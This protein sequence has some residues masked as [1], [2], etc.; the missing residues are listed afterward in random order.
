MKKLKVKVEEISKSIFGISSRRY[1]QLASDEIVPAVIH[2]KIDFIAASKALI[3]YYRNLAAG[4]G[5]L[6]LTDVRIRKEAARAE[7]EELIVKKLKGELVPKNAS[8]SWLTS[9][10]VATKIAFRGL[11]KRL[12]P[13]VIL[14]KDPREAYQIIQNE[15]DTIIRA[16]E[17]ALDESKYHRSKKRSNKGKNSE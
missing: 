8:I 14:C 1:R 9:L 3:T 4:Q 13:I 16:L 11:A 6:N 15:I 2:G 17:K 7:R 12:A 10:G 5:S